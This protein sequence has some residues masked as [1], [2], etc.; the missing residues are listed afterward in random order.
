MVLYLIGSFMLAA[1]GSCQNCDG[2]YDFGESRGTGTQIAAAPFSDKVWSL[3]STSVSGG[4]VLRK[5]TG[6]DWED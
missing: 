6:V 3:G 1:I 5:W 4:L 2:R